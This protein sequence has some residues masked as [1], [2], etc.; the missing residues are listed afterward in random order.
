MH[1]SYKYTI[2]FLLGGMKMKKDVSLIKQKVSNIKQK[3]YIV[4]Q[5]ENDEHSEEIYKIFEK[6]KKKFNQYGINL[7]LKTS[8]NRKHEGE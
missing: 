3:Q 6:Y 7:Y 8:L 2:N 1:Y 4:L 5:E